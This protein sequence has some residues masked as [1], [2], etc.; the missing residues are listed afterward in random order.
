MRA[1]ARTLRNFHWLIVP[2]A[3]QISSLGNVLSRPPQFMRVSAHAPQFS[4]SP[5]PYFLS[6]AQIVKVIEGLI[7]LTKDCTLKS[8]TIFLFFSLESWDIFLLALHI[9]KFKARFSHDIV[10]GL[11]WFMLAPCNYQD[12]CCFRIPFWVDIIFSGLWL[13]LFLSVKI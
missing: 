7:I 9:G 2:I 6:P 4:L 5:S 12:M 13:L 8:H 1:S 10:L 3:Y 11:S